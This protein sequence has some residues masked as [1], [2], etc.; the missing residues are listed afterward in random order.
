MNTRPDHDS[1]RP[2]SPM[3]NIHPVSHRH[4]S[5]VQHGSKVKWNTAS[6]ALKRDFG[7][8]HSTLFDERIPLVKPV[9]VHDSQ[10]SSSEIDMRSFS[11]IA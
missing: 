6:R 11:F 2:S 3:S 4:E 10:A 5:D 9:I 8:R 7:V 1:D